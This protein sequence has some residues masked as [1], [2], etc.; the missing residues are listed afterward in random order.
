MIAALINLCVYL[1]IAGVIYWAVVTILG[2]IPLPAPIKQ[3]VRV[4]LIV[5]LV[6][7]IVYALLGLIGVAGVGH[8]LVIR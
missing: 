7:I 3:V 6:L 1:I 5:I 2:V 8:P 4:I